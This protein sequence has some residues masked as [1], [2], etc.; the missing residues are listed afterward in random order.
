M[1][2]L[3]ILR[4]LEERLQVHVGMEEQ[5]L[6]EKHVIIEK[7]GGYEDN[8]IYHSTIAIQ[9]VAESLLKAAELNEEVKKA[10]RDIEELDDVSSCS[11]NSD[12]NFTNPTTK[13][14]RYQAVFNLV[15]Y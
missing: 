2:E 12:Y 7:T 3:S 13:K 4:F 8:Y 1:I 6:K 5:N 14:Y 15:H 11:L 9:S 10:M